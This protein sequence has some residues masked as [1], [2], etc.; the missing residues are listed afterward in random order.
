MLKILAAT[1]PP[2]A[3]DTHAC[4]QQPIGRRCSKGIGTPSTRQSPLHPTCSEG[5]KRTMRR[6]SEALIRT[7]PLSTRDL[8]GNRREHEQHGRLSEPLKNN[9]PLVAF[10][11]C[12]RPSRCMRLQL[13]ARRSAVL[14]GAMDGWIPRDESRFGAPVVSMRRGSGRDPGEMH[15]MQQAPVIAG[16]RAGRTAG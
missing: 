3:P 14:A 15:D 9:G 13:R 16:R 7:K 11:V 8:Q 1:D 10:A 12:R 4:M 5:R 6:I 2:A